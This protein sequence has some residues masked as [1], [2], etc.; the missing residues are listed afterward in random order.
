MCGVVLY[1][2]FTTRNIFFLQVVLFFSIFFFFKL[3]K[4]K[5]HI[6]SYILIILMKYVFSLISIS[7]FYAITMKVMALFTFL[8]IFAASL[9]YFTGL[10]LL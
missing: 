3:L 5:G 4:K 10:L 9:N 6:N 2:S 1:F 7:F 8:V